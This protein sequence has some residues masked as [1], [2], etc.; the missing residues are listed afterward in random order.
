MRVMLL[1][2]GYNAVGGIAEIVDSLAFELNRAGHTAAIV[3]TRDFQAQ[4][5]GY[6]RRP[7]P[8]ID[9]IYQEIWNRKPLGIRHLEA[10]LRI[11]WYRRF[12]GLAQ[13]LR[14]WRPDIINSHLWA[15]DRYPTVMSAC[16]SAGVPLV[17]SL[18]VTD[19]R[20][21]G[22]LGIRGLRA[23]GRAAAMIAGS[24]ATREFF[25]ARLPA[26]RRAHVIIGGVDGPAAASAP[27]WRRARP[28]LFCACR[29]HLQHKALD[30][31]IAAF[32][33]I[34]RDFPGPDLLIAGGGPDFHHV[35]DLV[36][37]SGC[38]ERIELLGVK[39]RDELRALHSGALAFVLPSRPGECLPLV[40]L[41][42]LAAG[43]PVV[44]TD[45][46]GAREVIFNGENG[47]LLAPGD[48]DGT[49]VALRRLLDDEPMRIAMGGRGK[50]LVA[51]KYTWEKC[52]ASYLDVYRRCLQNESR[53]EEARA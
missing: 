6:E 4:R 14:L 5:S 44:G 33:M 1:V 38:A 13:I 52:A 46:G 22:R 24:A 27:A 35:A 43:R 48:I 53:T 15:W 25:A 30:V 3:S 49:A 18:H 19:E 26:A 9:C 34:A 10:L 2:E 40:Y 23:L 42:A 20:G 21:R 11:P 47:F 16:V 32:R 51:E 36:K 39:S 7:R 12:G 41:E 50:R 28:Y 17:Q 29:L 37:N 31:L 45:T 8:G